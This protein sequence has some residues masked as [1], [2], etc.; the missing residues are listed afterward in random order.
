VIEG[1]AQAAQQQTAAPLF[2]HSQSITLCS[3]INLITLQ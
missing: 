3:S 2:R 1:A